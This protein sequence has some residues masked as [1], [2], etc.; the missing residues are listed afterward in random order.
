MGVAGS[1]TTAV[2]SGRAGFKAAQIIADTPDDEAR[3]HSNWERFKQV[4]PQFIPAAGV[5]AVTITS[6]IMSNR[7]S[8]REAA[9]LG[10]AYGLS[11]IADIY[12]G[13]M[14]DFVFHRQSSSSLNQAAPRLYTFRGGFRFGF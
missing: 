3:P 12:A 14:L 10:V 6:I 5:G 7:L 4:W 8:S 2:L 13:Q 11:R 9:A 1:V